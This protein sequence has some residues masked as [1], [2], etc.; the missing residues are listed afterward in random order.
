MPCSA[1]PLEMDPQYLE[2]AI[3]YA[4][5]VPGITAV[6]IGSATPEQL[7]Q[8]VAVVKAYRPLTSEERSLLET[9]GRRLAP[10]WHE[11]FGP[12]ERPQRT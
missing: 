8:N 11:R 6:N 2:L 10:A 5:G 12:A 7:R 3:R 4:M 1:G 9:V